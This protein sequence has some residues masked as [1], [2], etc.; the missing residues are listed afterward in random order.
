M[1]S[2]LPNTY[3]ILHVY[4]AVSISK[5]Q[6]T[7]AHGNI[8]STFYTQTLKRGEVGSEEGLLFAVVCIEYRRASPLM[9]IHCNCSHIFLGTIK[10]SFNSHQ[11]PRQWVTFFSF[12]AE[13]LLQLYL[14]SQ[15]MEASRGGTRLQGPKSPLLSRFYQNM[16]SQTADSV[17]R[18]MPKKLPLCEIIV[19]VQSSWFTRTKLLILEKQGSLSVQWSGFFI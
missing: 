13:W 12:Y 16:R 7:T 1:T 14:K 9:I 19:F 11:W 15:E 18:R 17:P 4:S 8:R 5:Q 6:S 2:C 10:C 3:Q